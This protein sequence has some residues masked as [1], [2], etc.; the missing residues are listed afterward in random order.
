MSANATSMFKYQDGVETFIHGKLFV[1][2]ADTTLNNIFFAC[3]NQDI[4]CLIKVLSIESNLYNNT[5]KNEIIICQICLRMS[6]KVEDCDSS[7][8][9]IEYQIYINV[10]I[11]LILLLGL[12]N[13]PLSFY[14]NNNHYLDGPP[15]ILERK[16]CKK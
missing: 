8:H 5:L 9:C 13:V 15:E 10:L 4:Y 11:C 12:P 16:L 2:P 1:V 14:A 7:P 3:K 6:C